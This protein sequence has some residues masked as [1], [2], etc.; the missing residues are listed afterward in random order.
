MLILAMNTFSTF[1]AS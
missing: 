1:K